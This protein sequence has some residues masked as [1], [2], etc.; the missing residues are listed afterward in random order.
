[1]SDP[2][3]TFDPA[4]FQQV[5]TTRLIGRFLIHRPVVETTMELARREAAEGA[6]HGTLVLAEEQTAGRGRRGRSFHSPPGENLY[7]TLVLRLPTA[8]HRRLPVAVPVA[9][10]EAVRAEGLDARIKWPNDVWVGERKLAGMLIDAESDGQGFLAYP[11]IGINVNGDPTLIPELRELATSVR[12]ELG[13]EVGREALLAR[14]CNGLEALLEGA[15]DDALRR[16][17]DL[18]MVLGREV[19]VHPT[20]GEPYEGLAVDLTADG[21]LRVRPPDGAEVTVTAADVSLR[22]RG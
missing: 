5:L 6:P 3:S 11:G 18:S 17:R 2:H 8:L 10:C 4:R 12:R 14:V 19:T 13:H 15:S 20:G 7:F 1:M 21:S 22:P 9:V 16:Y